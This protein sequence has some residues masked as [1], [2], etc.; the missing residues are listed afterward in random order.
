MWVVTCRDHVIGRS[1]DHANNETEIEI[2]VHVI[3][4]KIRAC[5]LA[6]HGARL[7][8][9]KRLQPLFFEF[10]FRTNHFGISL[11]LNAA[12]YRIGSSK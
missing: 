5:V 2:R 9:E 3:Y 12:A 8:Y 11:T 6:G 7:Q 10:R 4:A 1:R